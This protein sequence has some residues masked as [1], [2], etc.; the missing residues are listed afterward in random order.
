MDPRK[1]GVPGVRIVP[2]SP[3]PVSMKRR[4]NHLAGRRAVGAAAE[5]LAVLFLESRGHRV[6]ER[7]VKVGR[8]EIDILAL[9]NGERAV[10]EVRSRWAVGKR[11]PRDALEAFDAAKAQQVKKLAASPR[12]RTS[13]VDFIAVGFHDRRV[14]IHWTQRV[15]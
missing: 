2:P 7:N 1:E 6:L 4:T 8:G 9:I 12:A 3:Q 10:V 11:S 14:E 5:S 15:V 13:R